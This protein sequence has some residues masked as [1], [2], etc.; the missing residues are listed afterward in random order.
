MLY[1]HPWRDRGGGFLWLRTS[2]VVRCGGTHSDRHHRR[3]AGVAGDPERRRQQA[4]PQTTSRH[5][6]TPISP[7]SPI[8]APTTSSSRP[9]SLGPPAPPLY[10]IRFVYPEDLA[11]TPNATSIPLRLTA[12]GPVT[13]AAPHH[14]AA[15]SHPSPDDWN[16][17]YSFKGDRED[18]ATARFR[19]WPVHLCPAGRAAPPARD[20]CGRT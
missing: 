10:E 6:P 4:L 1:G 2:L 13:S 15:A 12:P 18:R 5:T 8:A 3:L 14:S 17:D 7:S 20:H 19:R 11:V 9:S 16:F